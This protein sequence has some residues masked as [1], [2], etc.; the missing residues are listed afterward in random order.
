MNSS[1][2]EPVPGHHP[3]SGQGC[4]AAPSGY[5]LGIEVDPEGLGE[6]LFAVAL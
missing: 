4:G 3:R 6:P 1:T 2:H 5:G